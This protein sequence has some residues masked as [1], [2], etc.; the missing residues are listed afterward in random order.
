MSRKIVVVGAGLAG[1]RA[2][3]QLRAQGWSEPILVIGEEV[4]PPYNR[5]P[6]TKSALRDGVD[7]A[8]LTFRQRA[9]TDDVEWRLGSRV[10]RADLAEH[11]LTVDDGSLL[12][13]DGLVVATGVRSRRL[14]LEAPLSQRHAIRT[15]Q[16]AQ[17]LHPL[18]TP[19][20]RVVV[21]GGG[22][23]GC[24]VAAAASGLGC[25]VTVVEPFTTPLE[26]PAGTLVGSEVQRRHEAHGVAFRL[27][28]T[29]TAI[30]QGSGVLSVLL[31]DGTALE[32]DVVVEAV[33]SVANTDWLLGQGLDLSNGVL[34]DGDLHPVTDAGP[35]ADVVAL[36]DVARFP[37][38]MFGST[39]YRIEHWTMPTDTA[40]HAARS[41]LR[42][43]GASP[44]D[45][46]AFSPLPS[47]WSDQY[48]TR[49]Q[50]FGMPALGLD[51]VRVLEGQLHEEAAVGF[52]RDGAL[53]GIVLFGMAK[54][55]LDYRTQI[56]EAAPAAQVQEIAP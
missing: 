46:P 24:E 13:Y 2:C 8:I 33:G 22:F 43:L 18:L 50:S 41:L 55:M 11:S 26:G 31:D 6:L 32:A 5:P 16:D 38:S 12:S 15:I 19:G 42:A 21:I 44:A 48:G 40:A 56:I 39:A 4:H 34:C 9:S 51:D 28:R 3:E 30:D 47:F 1:L 53:V 25:S 17:A 52:H 29:V 35:V 14:S 49:I 7:P 27:G 10:V 23:I 37:Y 20:A 45:A 36:G 54:K